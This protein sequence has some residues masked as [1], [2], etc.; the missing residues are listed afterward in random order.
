[1]SDL[2]IIGAGASVPYGFPAGEELFEK[3][4]NLNYEKKQDGS[5]NGTLTTDFNNLYNNED[6][7]ESV[8]KEAMYKFFIDINNSTMISVDDFLRNRKDLDSNQ[9]IFG[10]KVIARQILKAENHYKTGRYNE[11]G[12]HKEYK[13]RIDWL[14]ILF[15]F[16]DRKKELL[17]DFID[18]NFIILNYDRLFEYKFFEY[19]HY[20]KKY[21]EQK[22]FEQLN[23]MKI[24]HIYGYL[25]DLKDTAFGGIE[26]IQYKSIADKIK[27][28][29]EAGKEEKEKIK[30]YFENCNRIFFIGFGWLEDNMRELCLDGS[31]PKILRG[32]EI[33]GTAYKM[34]DDNI[35]NIE[36]RLKSCGTLQPNIKDCNAVNLIKDFF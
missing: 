9:L 3:I 14:N 1:M 30:N 28:V 34:S 16:I 33:Y 27:T 35:K 31:E 23:K 6:Y 12:K 13:K 18:S 29:W 11:N 15:S 36:Y 26:K 8:I 20:D 17:N 5:Y 4:R 7:P 32:K 10:K 24:T 2:F 21:S 22:A 25:G 19:L